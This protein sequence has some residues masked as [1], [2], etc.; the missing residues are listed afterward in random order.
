MSKN[1]PTLL[2]T[3][4][5]MRSNGASWAA[6][7]R[8]VG[9]SPRTC[10]QWPRLFRPAWDGL[11]RDAEGRRF[12]ETGGEAMAV[13]QGLLR[14]GDDRTKLRSADV[15]LRTRHQQLMLMPSTAAPLSVADVAALKRG[16]RCQAE[17]ALDEKKNDVGCATDRLPSATPNQID[18]PILRD[19]KELPS[20]VAP[21]AEPNPP[22]LPIPVLAHSAPR[23]TIHRRLRG[24]AFGVLLSVATL[25]LTA[26]SQQRSN[27]S[28]GLQPARY[29]TIPLDIKQGTDKVTL[30]QPFQT[31][32]LESMAAISNSNVLPPE[33]DETRQRILDAAEDIFAEIGYEAA[34]VRTICERAG[35]KN[36]GAVNYYFRGKEILYT[37]TVKNALRT[38]SQGAPFPEWSKGTLPETKLRDFIRVMMSRMMQSA[39]ISSMKL[40]MREFTQPS[41]ACREAV[42][43]YIQPMANILHGILQ[44]LLPDV[45]ME[46]RWMIGFS[47]VGQCLYYRQDRAVA[48][49]LIGTEAFAQLDVDR[50]AEHIAD[51]SLTALGFA[52]GAS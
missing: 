51:F 13:L 16:R 37:E 31:T 48:E 19:S 3:A 23:S 30:N 24:V 29:R 11:Y 20:S 42:L 32:V 1:T 17:N 6:V 21:R 38:C 33:S 50:V 26:V 41:S 27:A 5:E 22:A 2:R 15:L 4:A 8:T 7:G 10:Q 46:K 35:V 43:Q 52:G 18:N 39:K 9:R 14:D 12:T 45:P 40:M 36:I 34:T 47:I 28:A 49:I 44:E 25:I